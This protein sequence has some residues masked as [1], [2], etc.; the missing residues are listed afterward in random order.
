MLKKPFGLKQQEIPQRVDLKWKLVWICRPQ[1]KTFGTF[2]R[3]QIELARSIII[4]TLNA[5]QLK[6][7]LPFAV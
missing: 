7:N 5:K 4:M 3:T 2:S 1:N 6:N